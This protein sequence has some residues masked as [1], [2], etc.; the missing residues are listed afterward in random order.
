MGRSYRA[1]IEKGISRVD[2]INQQEIK[3]PKRKPK[4]VGQKQ[5]AGTLFA[6]RNKRLAIREAAL[7]KV[8]IVMTYQKTTTNET[9]KYTVAPYSWRYRRLKAGLRKM[10][11]A[12]DMQEKHIKGFVLKNVKNVAIT[13]RK[14]KPKWPIEISAWYL[15]FL[16]YLLF[17]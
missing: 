4:R 8:Q 9:K 5:K 14:F 15:T 7:R 12:Y 2:F 13:D 10:L 17:I 6:I 11:F 16:L 1:I 3:A